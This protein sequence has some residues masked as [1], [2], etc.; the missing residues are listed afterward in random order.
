MISKPCI[1]NLCHSWMGSKK[2]SNFLRIV[3][4]NVQTHQNSTTDYD[5]SFEGNQ[6]LQIECFEANHT[7]CFS[8]RKAIVLIPRKQI[9]Q[10][11]GANPE[12]S[13]FCKKYS[14]FAKLLTVKTSRKLS[15]NTR[16]KTNGKDRARGTP[17]PFNS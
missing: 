2:L 9:Q 17:I 6:I 12:P 10:S 3:L 16:R 8:T 13:A 4:P 11:N 14:C 7:C 1:I 15:I 5:Q